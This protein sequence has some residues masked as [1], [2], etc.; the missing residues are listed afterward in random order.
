[1][2]IYPKTVLTILDGHY[3]VW[4]NG[5]NRTGKTRLAIDLFTYY[6][7]AG[8]RLVSNLICKWNEEIE[9]VFLESNNQLNVVVILD[10]GGVFVR[11]K[12]TIRAIMGF[13]G[14]LNAIFMMPSTESPHEDLWGFYIEPAYGWNT[15]IKI[16]L[17][18]YVNENLFQIWR[19]TVFSPH[20]KN[21]RAG[22]F[23]QVNAKV[24]HGVYSSLNPFSNPQGVLSFFEKSL[25]ELSRRYKQSKVQLQDLATGKQGMGENQSFFKHQADARN[26]KSA[27]SIFPDKKVTKR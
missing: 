5:D 11:T 15:V 25:Q 16:L 24:F 3:F 13:K 12:E 21:D 7:D 1:M 18:S 19:W 20:K 9:D 6:G 26:A 22:L 27:R 17:G 2:P 4:I 23:V 14:K 10:E 8:F